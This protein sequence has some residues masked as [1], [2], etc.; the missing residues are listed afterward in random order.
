MNRELA[1]SGAALAVAAIA[2]ATLALSGAVA[3]PAEP[4]AESKIEGHASLLEVT[5]A[6]DDVSGETVSLEIDSYLEH[7]GQPVENVTVVHRATDTDTDLVEDQT[8]REV[9]TLED[10]SETV[11]T[12]TVDVPR[13][14]SYDLETF[15]YADGTRTESATHRVYGVDALTPAYADSSLEFH[16]FGGE[17]GPLADVP[18]IEY[19][20]VDTSD[21]GEATVEV[22]GYLT[23]AGDDPADDLELELK[24]RQIDS[25]VVA[26][27]DT[28]SVPAV[29]PGKTATPSTELEVADEYAYYLD[30]VLWHDGTIIA[31]DRAVADLGPDGNGTDATFETA[32]FEED[33]GFETTA[34][35]VDDGM[36]SDGADQATSDDEDEDHGGDGTPGFGFVATA[37]AVFAAI[38][39]IAATRTIDR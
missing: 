37:L 20:V 35:D 15:V 11:A 30:A 38:A 13:E 17:D 36:S 31:T 14:G 9:G 21:D 1:L 8:Y 23:N 5:I 25:N 39:V 12:A 27:A 7:R 26:D 33:D 34:G 22:T 24:A 18:A 19:S 3:D 4:D 32:D 16:R 29:D 2:L 6:A 28:V 10:G